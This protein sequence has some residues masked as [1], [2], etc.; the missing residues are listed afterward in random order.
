MLK[1]ANAEVCLSLHERFDA[2]GLLP[3]IQFVNVYKVS[4]IELFGTKFAKSGIIATDVAG[5]PALPVFG[6]IMCIWSILDFTYF[7]VQLLQ[8]LCF[9]QKHQAYHV[10]ENTEDSTE[11]CPYNSLVDFNV[12][13]SKKDKHNKYVPVI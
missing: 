8:T 6:V 7:D 9:D 12:F 1:K 2:L 11:I 13:R 5:N 10:I 4:W 3:G